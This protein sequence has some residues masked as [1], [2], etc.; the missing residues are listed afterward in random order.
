MLRGLFSDHHSLSRLRDSMRVQRLSFRM[1]FPNPGLFMIC[2]ASFWREIVEPIL[3]DLYHNG[4][5]TSYSLLQLLRAG[6]R[7]RCSVGLVALMLSELG[8]RKASIGREV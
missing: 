6:R 1:N 2:W 3:G 7:L 4:M 5:A 8:V